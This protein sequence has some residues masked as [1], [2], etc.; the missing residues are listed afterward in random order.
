[1]AQYNKLK[2]AWECRRGMLELDYMI[3]P[4]YQERFDS[5]S[6]EQQ[7]SFVE[8]LKFTD[9]ELFRWLMNQDT[10]PTQPL[11]EIVQLIQQ[12]LASK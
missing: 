7:V 3:M 1:M 9:P 2:L 10:A 11:R 5:L 4:F 8:L 12:H 6:E